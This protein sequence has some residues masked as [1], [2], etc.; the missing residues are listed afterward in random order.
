MADSQEAQ[1][2][3]GVSPLT[4]AVVG[5]AVGAAGSLAAVAL[6]NKETRRKIGKKAEELRVQGNK[7]LSEI[8][9]RAESLRKEAESRVQEG[10]ES[11]AK[12]LSKGTTR[13]T[14]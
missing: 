4:A 6:T 3:G 12:E 14:A 1:K 7:A 13:K 9:K 5:A 11:A 2:K 8:R 10:K